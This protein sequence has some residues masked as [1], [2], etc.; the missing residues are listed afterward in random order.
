MSS[1]SSTR[2]ALVAELM[3][4]MGQLL[5]RVEQVIQAQEAARQ[6]V[7][8]ANTDL[9]RQAGDLEARTVTF[10]E[11]AKIYLAHHVARRTDEVTRASLHAQT[12]AMADAARELFKTQVEPALHRLACVLQEQTLRQ[13]HPWQRWWT[14][15]ATAAVASAATWI[16]AW[17]VWLR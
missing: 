16:T 3:G 15:A 13:G 1:P 17:A 9:A 14:H 4:D 5:D 10:T 7:V 6:S 8:Q 11:Q 12:Q 2:E